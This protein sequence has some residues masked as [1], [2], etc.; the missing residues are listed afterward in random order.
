MIN[1]S[2]H[3]KFV[4]L[5]NFLYIL[6][7]VLIANTAIAGHSDKESLKTKVVAGRITDTYGESIPGAKIVIPETGETFFADMD[8]NFKFNLKTDK[9]YAVTVNTLGFEPLQVKSSHLTAFSDLS[10]RSL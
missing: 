10:L 1:E 9:D 3:F 6:L 4:A 2:L 7:V 5:K 8:G